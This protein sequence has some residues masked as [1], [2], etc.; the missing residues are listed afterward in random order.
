MAHPAARSLAQS[1]CVDVIRVP[2]DRRY[3]ANHMWLDRSG[4]SCYVGV[5]GF[6]ARVFG[7]VDRVSFP[8]TSNATWPSVVLTS[9]DIELQMTFPAVLENRN[10]NS[11]LRAD[12]GKV[13]SDPYGAGWL[14]EGRLVAEPPRVMD[15]W[16]AEGWMH[17]EVERMSRIVHERAA[18]SG[19]AADGGL[20]GEGVLRHLERED[21]LAVFN[22]FFSPLAYWEI[23]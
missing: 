9:G 1:E 6:A 7:Q 8:R 15:E 20:F 17:R 22:D 5:D 19:Y 3:T 14:F 4:D 18:E 12:P 11:Y 10:P 16:E 23:K 2:R 13:S 21:A